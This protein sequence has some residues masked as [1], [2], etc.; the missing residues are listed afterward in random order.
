MLSLFELLIMVRAGAERGKKKR[1]KKYCCC[2]ER[3]VVVDV[4]IEVSRVDFVSGGMSVSPSPMQ[5][6]PEL[7][8]QIHTILQDA[9]PD[10]PM[11]SLDS[12]FDPIATLNTLVPDGMSLFVT[13]GAA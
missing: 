2:C 11:S 3:V 7:V 9:S 4:C 1:L 6:P 12:V 5:L 8:L 10:D 13:N